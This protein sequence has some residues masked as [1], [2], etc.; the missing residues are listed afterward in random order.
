MKADL[1]VT[2][3][4]NKFVSHYPEGC[5]FEA[6]IQ[7]QMF[8]NLN[9]E[10]NGWVRKPDGP[11]KKYSRALDLDAIYKDKS[12]NKRVRVTY[13]LKAKE[14]PLA[15][16]K[17]PI[18][19]LTIFWGGTSQLDIRISAAY[20]I[21]TDVPQD[22][23]E[24]EV[25]AVRVKS[26]ISYDFEYFQVD[27]TRVFGY[28]G[29]S[30]EE[31]E[32]LTSNSDYRSKLTVGSQVKAFRASKQEWFPCTVKALNEK[33]VTVEFEDKSIKKLERYGPD[34]EH[35]DHNIIPDVSSEVEIELHPRVLSRE[36]TREMI[37]AKWL[38]CAFELRK[39]AMRQPQTSLP[40]S[41][42]HHRHRHRHPSGANHGKRPV[43]DQGPGG[44]DSEKK[45]K[46]ADGDREKK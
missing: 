40:Q 11:V 43:H 14:A 26:R 7:D 39:I 28:S 9:A 44:N 15:I 30:Q 38:R 23:Q 33:T 36:D 45:Q 27:I 29:I 22:M 3:G 37:I 16:L 5:K 2:E 12:G 20:E 8:R 32:M 21:P 18:P 42:H 24:W 35:K 10:L 34:V 4:K 6:Q 1:G 31:G 25:D 41:H 17:E 46:I 13:D 19:P